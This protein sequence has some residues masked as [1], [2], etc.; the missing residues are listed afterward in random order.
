MRHG[1]MASAVIRGAKHCHLA[2]HYDHFPLTRSLQCIQFKQQC[3]THMVKNISHLP[4][5]HKPY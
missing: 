2:G 4:A 3:N 1:L 5:G